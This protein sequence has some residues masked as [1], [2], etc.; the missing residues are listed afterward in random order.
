MDCRVLLGLLIHEGE[1]FR[2]GTKTPG[3]SNDFFAFLF[4]H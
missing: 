2:D 4:C 3:N 1:V